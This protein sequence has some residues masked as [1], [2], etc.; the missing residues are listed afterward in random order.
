[1][2]WVFLTAKWL[3][4]LE[5]LWIKKKKKGGGVVGEKKTCITY[6]EIPMG[7]KTSMYILGFYKTI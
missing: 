6:N 1:M 5:S 4:H 3:Q 2:I 7:L